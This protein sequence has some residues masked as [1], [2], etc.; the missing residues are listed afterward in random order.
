VDLNF[1]ESVADLEREVGR[2]SVFLQCGDFNG[3]DLANELKNARE[4]VSTLSDITDESEEALERAGGEDTRRGQRISQ[5]LGELE[6]AAVPLGMAEDALMDL[7]KDPT[8]RMLVLEAICQLDAT[9]D[10]LTR[11]MAV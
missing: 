4:C 3:K 6:D 11:A 1:Q 5:E 8:S 9:C 7:V 10:A 2:I